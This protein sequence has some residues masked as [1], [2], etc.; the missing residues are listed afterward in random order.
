MKQLFTL[1]AFLWLAFGA[2]AQHD[3]HFGFLIEKQMLQDPNYALKMAQLEQQ[4]ND[5]MQ[6][7]PNTGNNRVVRII[8]VAVHVVYNNTAQNVSTASINNLI[9]TLNKDYRRQNTDTSQTRTAFKSVAADAQIQFCLDTIIRKSTTKT[10]FDPDTET[11]AMKSN[12]TGGST[13]LNTRYY[14]NIWIVDLC[15]NTGGGVAGYAYLPTSGMPGSSID[16][17]VIDYSLGYNN[18]TGRTATHEIGHYLG[19]KHTWGSDSNPSCGS[20]DGFSDTPNTSGPFYSCS[21]RNTCSTPTPGDQ[22][23]NFMDYSNCPNM[24]TIQQANYMNGVLS[25][26]SLSTGRSTLFTSPGCNSGGLAPTAEFAANRTVLC[27]GQSVTFTDASIGS[28]SSFSWTM[29]GAT[30]ATSTAQNPTV[31]Y[32]TPGTYTVT[33]TVTNAF[34]SDG[35]TKINYITVVS[36]GSL[37]V[38]QDFQATTFPPT[39]WQLLNYDNTVTWARKTGVG[40]YTVGSGAASAFVD[41]YNYNAAGSQDLLLMPSVTFVG[42]TNGRLTFDY[43][44]A[45]YTGT[46]G[47]ASDSLLVVVSIDC[48]QTFYLLQKKGGTQLATRT[49][50]GTA[51]TPTATQWKTDTISLASLVGQQNVQIGFINQTGY[52]NNLYIDNINLSVPVVTSP[53]VTNFVGNPTTIPV[54]SSVAFTDLST[55]NP[56]SWSWSFPGAATTTSTTQNPTITYNTVGTYNVSLTATNAYGNNT[57]TKVNYITVVQPT[58]GGCDTIDIF[59][60]QDTLALYYAGATTSSGYL[61]GHNSNGE[62]AKANKYTAVVSGSTIKGVYMYFGV[63]KTSN[64][65]TVNVRVWDASGAG[66]SPG[67]TPLATQVVPINSLLTNGLT[68]INFTTPPTVTGSYY[69]GVE[70]AY[71]A[72]DTIAIL[73]NTV[74]NGNANVGWGKASNG[75]WNSY[76]TAYGVNLKHIMYPI[77]CS[78]GG[79]QPDATFTANTTAICAGG[80]VAFT[81]TSTNA[82]SYSWSFPGGNPATSTATSPTV[83]YATSGTYNVV[84]VATGANGQD[85]ETKTG[86]IN[87][88]ATPVPS[89]TVT[90]VACNNGTNGSIAINVTGGTGPY[91]YLWGSGAT[92]QNR[93]NLVAGT[94]SVTVTDANGCKGSTSA[95]VTQPAPITLSVTST[96]ATC[97]ANN[98]T[99]TVNATGGNTPYTYAWSTGAITQTINNLVPGTYSVTVSSANGCTAIGNTVVSGPTPI[100]LTFTSTAATCA[101]SNGSATVT[102]FGGS[103]P[104]TYLWSNGATTTAANNLAAGTYTVTVTGA[105][106][107][108]A[109]GSVVVAGAV[110]VSLST[111]TSPAGCGQSNGSI[112]LTVSGGTT[113]YTF[114]WSNGRNTQN[115][116]AIASGTYTVTVTSANGCT[117]TTSATVTNSGGATVS[118][119]N[120]VHVSCFNGNNGSLNVG[121]TGGTIPY[122]YAWSNGGNTASISNLVAGTYT[123]TV[124]DGG[125]CVATA[126]GT[127]NQP[128]QVISTVSNQ[129]NVSCFGASNGS[130][131]VSATGGN[132]SYTYNWGNGIMGATRANLAA[133]TYPVSVTDGNGCV[134]PTLPVVISQPT[135]LAATT[136]IVNPGCSSA[137]GSATVTASGGTAPYN[138]AWSSGAIT[139]QANNLTA[140]NY[141]VT[142]TDSRGCTVNA[143]VALNSTTGP[144]LT[145]TSTPVGCGASGNGTATA[146]PSGGTPPYTYQWNDANNQTTQ[147]AS[148]LAAGNYT[149][150]VTDAAGCT[151][152]SNVTV[153]TLGAQVTYNQTNVTGCF[154]NS[155]GSITLNVSG[156]VGPYSYAWTNG[157]ITQNVSNLPAGTYTVTI[158]DAPGCGTIVKVTIAEPSEVE[159]NIQVTPTAQ[160]QSTGSASVTASGGTAPYSYDWSNSGTG[161]STNGLAVGNHTVTVTDANGC[162][163]TFT[164]TVTVGTGIVNVVTQM[165]VTIHP[166][167]STGKFVV[168]VFNNQGNETHVEIY[169]TLGQRLFVSDVKL[170]VVNGFEF[171]LNHLPANTYFVRIISG[172]ETA[173]RKVLKV[174]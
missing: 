111:S 89:A 169:N 14:L 58:A 90:N 95:T 37:P 68:Y 116:T 104:F 101:G 133:G 60:N 88:R 53:P 144:T 16:G 38:S 33:L 48:G 54:G 130:A 156:S 76:A 168:T 7:N 147:V 26:T 34:G 51:F 11:D 19:L 140:G 81:N 164:F 173:V 64:N 157:Q 55:N 112:T 83:T 49:A 145:L 165:G 12:A 171:D 4:V 24:F 85:T 102:V 28:P 110:G 30:P 114:A 62:V 122:T 13:P 18:G 128:T 113:P 172:N 57:A 170:D 59:N 69:V 73:T 8:S 66:G 167:P 109:T 107:C 52:G 86:Y 41:N 15:G 158:T 134:A 162:A 153:A 22:Y 155:N 74:N 106:T 149:V 43:A 135:Q 132:G 27:P 146:A 129:T 91:T 166:N 105:N 32:N 29:T 125:G 31:V 10:C 3:C 6:Q 96:A 117:A 120:T 143:S 70:Y 79:V 61:S 108:T 136:A 150:T 44:Y 151:T 63:A 36:A 20:D 138:Y 25:N 127:I 154:G 139:A 35:E 152:F 124:T 82:T 56:T 93:T 71:A 5:Y 45:Q 98:G 118:I 92:T 65:R 115:N 77:E 142:I 80:T 159:A 42:V 84:L 160:G 47:T 99:A 174:D 67:T 75:V 103:A 137:N 163:R 78:P 123:V 9:N 1:L 87:V 131:T 119:S 17:L 97:S 94:Y 121:V 21:A 161:T 141:T 72:G 23:E 148:S 2:S 46:G 50:T 39:N 126:A 40:G 100:S